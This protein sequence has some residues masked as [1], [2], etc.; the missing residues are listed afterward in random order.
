MNDGVPSQ[1]KTA[2]QIRWQPAA[3][4][5]AQYLSAHTLFSICTDSRT[6]AASAVQPVPPLIGQTARPS[7]IPRLNSLVIG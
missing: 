1:I 3:A 7:K 4:E 5:P 2:Y 6:Q